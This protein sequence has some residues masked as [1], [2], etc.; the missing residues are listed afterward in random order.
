MKTRLLVAV[1]AAA[2]LASGGAIDA[3]PQ[4]GEHISGALPEAV[5]QATRRYQDV[6]VAELDGYTRAFGCVSGPT[7]GAM[8]VHYVNGSLV[9][10]VLDAEHP[11]A[12]VYEPLPNGRLRLVAAEYITPAPVWHMTHGPDDTPQLEGHLLN[13]VPGPNRYGAAAFYEIHVWAWQHNNHGTF[14]DWNPNV[15][16]A[17]WQNPMP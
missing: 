11:E 9:D 12:L 4:H 1:S 6:A 8:G 13:Y 3:A 14:A 16:C 5:R 10:A 7:E 17:A 15:T 2:L